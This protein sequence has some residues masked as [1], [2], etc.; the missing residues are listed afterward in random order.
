[1]GGEG[2][3]SAVV[4]N[5][6]PRERRAG[7]LTPAPV[8]SRPG[9]QGRVPPGGMSHGARPTSRRTLTSPPRPQRAVVSSFHA[10]AAVGQRTWIN[11]GPS[12][13]CRNSATYITVGVVLIAAFALYDT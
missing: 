5:H 12:D 2:R 7:R 8:R 11:H 13:A 9:T 3:E 10:S 1:M 6:P 4:M